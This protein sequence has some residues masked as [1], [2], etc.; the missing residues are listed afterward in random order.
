M[1]EEATKIFIENGF[2]IT[3]AQAARLK[4]VTKTR[5]NQ[6]I[7]EGKIKEIKILGSQ[8]VKFSDLKE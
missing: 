4:G 7:K 3:K 2:L 6:M 5:I 8:M 1:F